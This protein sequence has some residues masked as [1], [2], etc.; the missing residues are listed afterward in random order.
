MTLIKQAKRWNPAVSLILDSDLLG[1]KVSSW[2]LCCGSWH[3]SDCITPN[4][5]RGPP[6]FHSFLRRL[7]FDCK[8]NDTNLSIQWCAGRFSFLRYWWWIFLWSPV[9][10]SPFLYLVKSVLFVLNPFRWWEVKYYRSNIRIFPVLIMKRS[11]YN[12]LKQNEL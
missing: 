8:G 7:L 11:H 2:A 12:G 10:L 5:S 1:S 9:S 4:P 3:S 6:A